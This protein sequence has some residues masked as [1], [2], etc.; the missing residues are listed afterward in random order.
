MNEF[1]LIARFFSP[2]ANEDGY[3]FGLLDDAARLG[4]LEAAVSEVVDITVDSFAGVVPVGAN[5]AS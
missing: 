2:L 4:S 3:A 5:P 1:E